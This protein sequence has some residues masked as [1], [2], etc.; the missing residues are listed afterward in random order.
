MNSLCVSLKNSFN[1]T[2]QMSLVWQSFLT[3]K[4]LIYQYKSKPCFREYEGA[5]CQCLPAADKNT[6][7]LTKL[8]LGQSVMTASTTVKPH[9]STGIP[10]WLKC[11][12]EVMWEILQFKKIPFFS[13]AFEGLRKVDKL[14]G[15]Y[16]FQEVKEYCCRWLSMSPSFISFWWQWTCGSAAMQFHLIRNSAQG[17]SHQ[18]DLC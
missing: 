4:H 11:G 12:P 8:P 9:F 10:E 5:S 15:Y 6:Y 14:Q 1:H 2:L 16:T 3:C 13:K 17:T 18:H 7:M